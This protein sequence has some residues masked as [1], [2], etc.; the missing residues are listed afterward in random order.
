MTTTFRV[1]DLRTDVIRL[2]EQTVSDVSSPEEAARKALG[3]ELE[4]AGRRRKK[5]QAR[6]YYHP[7]GEP[8]TV[9]RLYER[10]ESE[11]AQ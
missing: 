11:V 3:I 2:D 10:V 4:Q 5:L 6:V 8:L 7:P 9:V 1:I